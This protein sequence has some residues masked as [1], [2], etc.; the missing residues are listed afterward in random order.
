M[1]TL[2]VRLTSGACFLLVVFFA[3]LILF[4]IGNAFHEQ[5][6]FHGDDK[7]AGIGVL[8]YLVYK[9]NWFI[10][11]VDLMIRECAIAE[12]KIQNGH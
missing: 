3:V 7:L 8:K 6:I 4:K 11:A 12:I 10:F 2:L 5:H 1:I 9:I